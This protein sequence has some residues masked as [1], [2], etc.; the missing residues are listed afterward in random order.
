[1]NPTL[2]FFSKSDDPEPWRQAI[3]QSGL[4]LEFRVWPDVGPLENVR[5]TLVWKPPAGLH[6]QF[7]NLRAIL[8]L[9]AGV[10]GILSDP[11]RPSGIPITRL[12]DAGFGQQMAEYACYGAL[13]F[14]RR[15]QA[16]AEQQRRR[17]WVQLDP[18]SK[19]SCVI[20][21]MGLGVLG[22][23][24]V[25]MLCALGFPVIGWS[26]N[27]KHID[28]VQC[29]AGDAERDE[30][31]SRTRILVN[32]LPLT[33]HTDGM[34]NG[35]FLSRLPPGAFFINVARGRHVVEADLLA[36]LDSGQIDSA[37]LDVFAEEPL[38]ADHKFWNHPK[39]VV[40]PHVAGV[41][42][43]EEA[44]AQVMDNLRRLEG[45]EPPLNIVDVSRGY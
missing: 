19:Q 21:V 14:Y 40:T 16:Y 11:D 22:Q 18:Y 2:L 45:G 5:Y 37:M 3:A 39:V 10:D 42:L 26:R 24:A 30:F 9:G 8:S 34:I 44:A 43:A 32:F 29:Y 15:M 28:G 20:G 31:L 33:P 4:D 38:R 17:E 36:A 13:H 25:A 27:R 6:K 41:T 23:Q 12:V 1:M 7:P 35:D